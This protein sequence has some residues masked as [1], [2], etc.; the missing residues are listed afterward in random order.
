MIMG[1]EAGLSKLVADSAEERLVKEDQV[2]SVDRLLSKLHR[3]A[4]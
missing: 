1:A 3:D 2:A 4:A